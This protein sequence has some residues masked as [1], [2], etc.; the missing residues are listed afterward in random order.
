MQVNLVEGALYP[1]FA[2]I[3]TQAGETTDRPNELG[4]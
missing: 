1:T 2:P 4:E 3:E